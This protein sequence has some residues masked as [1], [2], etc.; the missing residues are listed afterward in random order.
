[1]NC[2]KYDL[3]NT[4]SEKESDIKEVSSATQWIV[5]SSFISCNQWKKWPSSKNSHSSLN[6][7]IFPNSS[8]KM[9]SYST[10]AYIKHLYSKQS[11]AQTTRSKTA[12]C[13]IK[14]AIK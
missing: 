3:W 9:R 8:L 4:L 1:V 7:L 14:T 2:L 10:H 6:S 12:P 11:V 5:K 13:P